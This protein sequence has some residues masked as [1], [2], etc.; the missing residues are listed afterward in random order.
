M[1]KGENIP[2]LKFQN[3]MMIV[4]WMKVKCDCY[5]IIRVGWSWQS[6]KMLGEQNQLVSIDLDVKW[7]E[8]PKVNR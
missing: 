3:Q 5:L 6:V 2:K 4:K 7:L 1:I 8:E